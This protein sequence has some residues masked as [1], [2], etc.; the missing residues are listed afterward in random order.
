MLRK[1]VVRA[2]NS[3]V[4]GAD[5]L[6]PKPLH[7]VAE[8][9]VET[10]NVVELVKT[11]MVGKTAFEYFGRKIVGQILSKKEHSRTHTMLQIYWSKYSRALAFV[12]TPSLNVSSQTS[13]TEEDPPVYSVPGANT[14]NEDHLCAR[15]KY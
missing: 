12:L 6:P 10:L 15:C 11:N 13:A 7:Q 4:H 14:D 2:D 3:F 8:L 1:P 5:C 9:Q